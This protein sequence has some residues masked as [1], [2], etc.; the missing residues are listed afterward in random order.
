MIIRQKKTPS[1]TPFS[2]LNKG[3]AF[4]AVE[5]DPDIFWMKTEYFEIDDDD[6]YNA[7]DLDSGDMTFFDSYETVIPVKVVAVEE[8]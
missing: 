2:S 6:G 3:E 4:H 7:V 1:A 8:D 5:S